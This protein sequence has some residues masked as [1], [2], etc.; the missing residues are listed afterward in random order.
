MTNRDP[1]KPD[2]VNKFQDLYNCLAN[3]FALVNEDKRLPADLTKKD[4]DLVCYYE[5]HQLQKHMKQN[6][7]GLHYNDLI[8]LNPQDEKELLHLL[9]QSHGNKI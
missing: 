3:Y 8:K 4:V 1:N 6:S 9:S 2:F 5:I 7:W